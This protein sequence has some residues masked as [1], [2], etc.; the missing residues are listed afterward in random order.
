MLVPDVKLLACVPVDVN[1]QVLVFVKFL[2]HNI[3]FR[4]PELLSQLQLNLVLRN[5]ALSV[6]EKHLST[7]NP[8][9]DAVFLIKNNI[10]S[11]KLID[12]NIHRIKHLTKLRSMIAR[13]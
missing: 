13:M 2:S 9:L 11:F 3:F 6:G 5:W 4:V 1:V 7:R 12:S 8:K 10:F